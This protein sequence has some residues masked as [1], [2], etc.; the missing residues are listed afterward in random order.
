MLIAML[1]S[2]EGAT[3]AEIVVASGWQA[4]YADVRIM[5]M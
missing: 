5:P 1:R 3:I 4:H 2:P